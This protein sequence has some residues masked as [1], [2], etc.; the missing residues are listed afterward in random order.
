MKYFDKYT[1]T[2][3]SSIPKALHNAKGIYVWKLKPAAN[4]VLNLDEFYNK[5]KEY[6]V[7]N[8][9]DDFT[10]RPFKIKIKQ[11]FDIENF[12]EREMGKDAIK[13]NASIELFAD[14]SPYLYIGK[15]TNLRQR[16]SRH[17]YELEHFLNVVH[18]D[19]QDTKKKFA[20]P[21]LTKDFT[22]EDFRE[23]DY[24]DTEEYDEIQLDRLDTDLEDRFSTR[25]A[26]MI[27]R[28]WKEKKIYSP[29]NIDQLE[30]HVYKFK[31]QD[32]N[33]NGILTIENFLIN[34][35]NPL[36]NKQVKL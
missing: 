14:L 31:D 35:N 20:E 33:D 26:K 7:V 25:F 2:T 22:E 27:H 16:I 8:G 1:I 12:G 6:T 29:P 30:C 4:N 17:F 10:K 3:A 15:S 18:S 9:K 11:L 34:A 21:N 23:E 24:S 19:I 32:I 28:Y 36:L 5:T 13:S